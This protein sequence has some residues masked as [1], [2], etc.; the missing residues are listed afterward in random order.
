MPSVEVNSFSDMI[1]H[2]TKLVEVK[3]RNF[4]M[5]AWKDLVDYTPVISGKARASW[6][7]SPNL[8]HSKELPTGTHGYPTPPNLDKYKRNF[9]VWY[10]ANTAPYMSKLNEGGSTQLGG[11]EGWIDAII[12]RNIARAGR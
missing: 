8:P 5:S 2:V 1:G 11:Q 10:I 12:L 9:S 3:K 4:L 6:F 7:I